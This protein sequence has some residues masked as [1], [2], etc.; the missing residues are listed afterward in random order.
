M[1]DSLHVP[2]GTPLHLVAWEISPNPTNRDELVWVVIVDPHQVGGMVWMRG[3]TCAG[4][5][6]DCASGWCFEARVSVAAIR[7]NIDGAR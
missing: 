6:P 4:P 7:A 2:A 3:H 1:T 5:A